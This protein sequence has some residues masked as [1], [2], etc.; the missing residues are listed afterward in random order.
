VVTGIYVEQSANDLHMAQLMLLA[1]LKLEWFC[2]SGTGL[3]RL[4][5]K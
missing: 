5:W 2:L 4:S 1:S 3:L